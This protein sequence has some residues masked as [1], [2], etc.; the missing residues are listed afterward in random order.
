M[1]RKLLTAA[2]A[3][4]AIG[5]IGAGSSALAAPKGNASG[6]WAGRLCDHIGSTTGGVTY[7]ESRG[8][9]SRE[10][11]VDAEAASLAKGEWDPADWPEI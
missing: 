7:W 1:Q 4:A 9:E 8:Y 3:C 5:L 2:V 11:C 10:A 6:Y